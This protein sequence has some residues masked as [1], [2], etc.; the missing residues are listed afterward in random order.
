M[1]EEKGPH[2]RALQEYL[3]KQVAPTSNPRLLNVSFTW[4]PKA[5]EMT[6]EERCEYAL[7]ALQAEGTP[8]DVKDIDGDL[9]PRDVREFLES[10]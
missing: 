10:K 5:A 2:F 7:Q 8:V 3:A 9:E 6:E 4:G 1:A